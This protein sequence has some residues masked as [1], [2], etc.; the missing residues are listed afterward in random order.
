MSVA[1]CNLS[2]SN[3]NAT[4]LL[5]YANQRTLRF[6][7]FIGNPMDSMICKT[8]NVYAYVCT[9]VHAYTYVYTHACVHV[10]AYAYTYVRIH[11]REIGAN[12]METDQYFTKF[13]NC[14][15]LPL[16]PRNCQISWSCVFSMERSLKWIYVRISWYWS[17]DVRSF[18]IDHNRV[19]DPNPLKVPEFN[20]TVNLPIN[21]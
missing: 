6:F 7:C 16:K 8:N 3:C 2:E 5:V 4:C 20:K 9:C 17:F 21:A 15:H 13:P 14:S 11:A 10:R 18:L 1:F 12:I 19:C